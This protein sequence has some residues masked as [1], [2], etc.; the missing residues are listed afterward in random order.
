MIIFEVM[1]IT[2]TMKRDR[3]HGSAL[4]HEQGPHGWQGIFLGVAQSRMACGSSLQS[5]KL[6]G[7]PK[8]R[9]PDG[10]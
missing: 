10:A 2:M 4:G 3:L 8:P 5:A 6:S 1:L 7:G 9:G